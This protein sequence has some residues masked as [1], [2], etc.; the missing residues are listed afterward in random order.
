MENEFLVGYLENIRQ[1]SDAVKADLDKYLEIIE[2]PKNHILLREGQRC[3]YVYVI[4]KGIARMYYLKDEEEVCSRFAEDQQMILSVDSFY[5][6][7]PGYEYIETMEP[8]LISRIHYDSLEKLYA[9]HVEFNHIGRMITQ[10]YFVRS[11]E[12]LFMLRKHTAEER[13]EMF[14]EKY[15]TLLQRVP[16]KYIASYLGLTLETLSRIRN[17]R[18]RKV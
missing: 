13:Y 2:V 9:E 1:L 17:K 10:L 18:S 15:P 7:M 8:S 14:V 3:D 12:R 6:R 11:E 5:S 4:L 16:L